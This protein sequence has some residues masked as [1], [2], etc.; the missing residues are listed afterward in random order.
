IE[1]RKYFELA[2]TNTTGTEFSLVGDFQLPFNLTYSTDA[3][4]YF[5][6]DNVGEYTFE[7][8]NSVKLNLL[9]HISLDYKFNLKKLGEEYDISY[10][11]KEH[12]LFLRITY[13]LR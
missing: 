13:F 11:V 3:D 8:E 5:P 10:L 4:F 9:K 1:H 7:W 2:S 12:S 6:F